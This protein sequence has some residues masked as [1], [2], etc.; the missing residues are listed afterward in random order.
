MHTLSVEGLTRRFG[1][2]A[3]FQDVT[4]DVPA[5][6]ATAL[7]GPNGS[8]KSTLLRCVVAADSPDAGTVLFEGRTFDETD[9]SVRAAVA[10]VLDD[11]EFFPDLSA[12]EHLHLLARA[13]GNAGDSVEG[14]LA[15]VVTDPLVAEELGHGDG[16]PR[17][18][19]D[20]GDA[21][22]RGRGVAPGPVRVF[23]VNL[24]RT[25]KFAQAIRRQSGN[26][27]ARV[28]HG[29]QPLLA[30]GLAD[31]RKRRFEKA[32]VET[33]VVCHEYAP[34]Q[35][36]G[37]GFGNFGKAGSVV[38][39]LRRDA[40]HVR[41]GRRNIPKWIHHGVK[42]RRGC[43]GLVNVHHRNFGD[44]VPLVVQPGGLY[45]YNGKFHDPIP[46]LAF[47]QVADGDPK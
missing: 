17:R 32:I 16:V 43:A 35:R 41:N 5:G 24:Q 7:L 19:V 12:I 2:R 15:E 3:V 30:H 10:T 34:F 29:A 9:A 23:I 18:R 31:N 8:G 26:K 42:S 25:A 6:T 36:A 14:M 22:R 28:A 27:L 44:A 13:H 37:Q 20:D 33:D 4:F 21:E 38:D 39:Q 45:V 11:V 47:P 1:S 40:G 46:V